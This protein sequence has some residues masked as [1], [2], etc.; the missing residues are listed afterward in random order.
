MRNYKIQYACLV[1]I[2]WNNE[3]YNNEKV[4]IILKY[5]I[6]RTI[7]KLLVLVRRKNKPTTFNEP[8]FTLVSK[9]ASSLPETPFS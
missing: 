2:I 7:Y 5:K 6:F 4:I 9:H 3:R 8:L 1:R